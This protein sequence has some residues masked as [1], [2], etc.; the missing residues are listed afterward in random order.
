MWQSDMSCSISRLTLDIERS[1]ND[2]PRKAALT[3][4][5]TYPILP[6]SDLA[7]RLLRRY[8]VP[9]HRHAHRRSRLPRYRA[10][11]VLSD[12]E[13]AILDALLWI[14]RHRRLRPTRNELARAINL[15]HPEDIVLA[16]SSLLHRRLIARCPAI[17]HPPRLVPRQHVGQNRTSFL[18]VLVPPK[19]PPGYRYRLTMTTLCKDRDPGLHPLNPVLSRLRP[20]RKIGSLG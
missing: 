18:A 8:G 20:R 6:L 2:S 4:S 12:R 13:L 19:G 7:P 5:R 9:S 17:A 11:F 10:G 1:N 15:R 3:P 16:L 14:K